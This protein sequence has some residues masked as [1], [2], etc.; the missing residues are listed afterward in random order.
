MW[1]CLHGAAGAFGELV[2]C[3]RVYPH[4]L[5]G[6]HSIHYNPRWPLATEV[7]LLLKLLEYS[8]HGVPWF[9]LAIGT[10]LFTHSALLREVGRNLFI[11]LVADIIFAAAIKAVVRRSRPQYNVAGE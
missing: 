10:W 2:Q 4:S 8:G 1:R 3:S 6:S 7:R 5:L 9:A 11:G